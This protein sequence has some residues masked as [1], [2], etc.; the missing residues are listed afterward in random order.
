MTSKHLLS[1][2]KVIQVSF[3][4][5]IFKPLYIFSATKTDLDGVVAFPVN[6]ELHKK[7]LLTSGLIQE[8]ASNP[9]ICRQIEA[10]VRMWSKKI[11]RVGFRILKSVKT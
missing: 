3:K 1:F 7:Y 8:A 9:E 6:K 10:I 11:E 4:I 5:D 2:C